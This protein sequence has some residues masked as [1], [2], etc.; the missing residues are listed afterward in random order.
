MFAIGNKIE[1]KCNEGYRTNKTVPLI[2]KCLENGTW[3]SVEDECLPEAVFGED[4]YKLNNKFYKFMRQLQDWDT[5]KTSC[6]QMNGN[7]VH[8][9]SKEEHEFMVDIIKNAD[10]YY[11]YWIGGRRINEEF[12]WLDGPT[13]DSGYR[14]WHDGQPSSTPGVEDYLRQSFIH[15]T[16]RRG[17]PAERGTS[18][19]EGGVAIRHVCP[20]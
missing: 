15:V 10:D 8:I 12:S 19:A 20:L 6:Y 13:F 4:I 17:V 2:S 7:L 14:N 11:C 9:L 16:S 1:Y 3:S 18:P 5:A